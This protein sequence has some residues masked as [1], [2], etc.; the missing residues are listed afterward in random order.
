MALSDNARGAAMLTGAMAFFVV[1]DAAMKLAAAEVPMLQAMAI[2]GLPVT[3]AF[4][5]IAW[6]TGALAKARYLLDRLVLARTGTELAGSLLFMPAL[7]HIPIATALALNQSVPLLIVPLA[8]LLL[9]EKVGWRRMSAVAIGFAGVLLILRPGAENLDPWLLVS[10][11]S[12]FFFA[13]RDTITRMIGSHVPS[14][15]IALA[16][17]GSV[18]TACAIATAIAGWVPMTPTAWA[19]IAF[20]CV[21]VSAGYFLSVAAMRTGELTLTGAFRYSALVWAALL[22]WIIWDELPDLQGWVGIALIVASGLYALHRARVRA[23]AA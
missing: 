23:R 21:V 7:A 14:M 5:L 18:M 10:F 9:G 15:L 12:A 16:M 13:I 4:L 17:S 22:G 2:R 20:A 6:R 11:A 8:V 19:A 1:N 3:L